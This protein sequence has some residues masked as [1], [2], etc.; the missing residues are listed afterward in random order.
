MIT[1]KERAALRAQANH[2]TPVL[3]VG[4]EGISENLV[5]QLD[6]VLTAR[7]LIKGSVQENSPFTAREAA[8]EL[9]ARVGADI[10]QVIGR[11]FVLWRESEKDV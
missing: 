10:V 1:T 5:A 9:A 3:Y 2:L 11:K 8:Q 4:K 6:G 7:E